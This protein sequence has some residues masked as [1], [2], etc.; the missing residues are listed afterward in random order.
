MGLRR[1]VRLVVSVNTRKD[2]LL[3][4]GISGQHSVH[5]VSRARHG[6][7]SWGEPERAPHVRVVQRVRLY[8]YI[9][10]IYIYIYRTF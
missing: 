2:A 4:V 8:I 7:F 6:G 1:L 9:I 5:P 10:Y 3:H